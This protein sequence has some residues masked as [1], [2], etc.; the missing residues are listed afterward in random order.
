MK[1]RVVL[2]EKPGEQKGCG[3]APVL[4]HG[5]ANY[6]VCPFS[7]WWKGKVKAWHYGIGTCFRS[8]EPPL[9]EPWEALNEKANQQTHICEPRSDCFCLEGGLWKEGVRDL[10]FLLEG[11]TESCH[12]WERPGQGRNRKG[13][14]PKNPRISSTEGPAT[15]HRGWRQLRGSLAGKMGDGWQPG[16]EKTR[17]GT[18]GTCQQ[19]GTGGSSTSP[20]SRRHSSQQNKALLQSAASGAGEAGAWQSRGQ[21]FRGNSAHRTCCDGV[22]RI[23]SCC[24]CVR[25]SFLFSF[26][27]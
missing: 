24:F 14:E 22:C 11:K 23:F 9:A 15:E 19:G 1:L 7:S 6:P 26:L 27:M 20:S 17:V 10:P 5:G 25:V 2:T 13:T 4:L 21:D 3:T 12:L 18:Q 16:K 8:R